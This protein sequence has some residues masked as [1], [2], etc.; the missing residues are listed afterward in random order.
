MANPPRTPAKTPRRRVSLTSKDETPSQFSRGCPLPDV[1]STRVSQIRK[2]VSASS[3]PTEGQSRVTSLTSPR[4][5]H[6]K[7][8]P[9][10][11]VIAL[12][13]AVAQAGLPLSEAELFEGLLR[14]LGARRPILSVAQLHRTVLPALG[15]QHES[16]LRHALQHREA[17]VFLHEATTGDGRAALAI[18]LLPLD[19]AGKL[20]LLL[21]VELLEQMSHSFVARAVA[22]VLSE[23][24][25]LF[26]RVLAVV[27]SGSPPM[28]QAFATNGI[29]G[30]VLSA[31]LHVPCLLHQLE[32]MMELWPDRL[33]RLGMLL[34][35][36]E[37]TFGRRPALRHRYE[38]FLQERQLSLSL[39]ILSTEMGP[40]AWLKKATSIAEHLPLLPEFVATD[41]EEGPLMMK[42]K[43][44]LG[45]S[46]EELVAE[47]TFVAE[48]ASSLLNMAHFLRQMGEPLA[49]RV[50]G[51]LD[52]LRVSFSYHLDTRLGPNTER[53][54]ALC[55]PPLM[56]RFRGILARSLARLEHLFDS[57][58]AMS[59]LRAV[60]VLDPKQL[61]AVGRSGLE[62]EQ[63]IPG[64]AEV[65]EIEWFRYQHLAEA[66]P[67]NVSLPQWWEVHA[68]QLPTLSPLARRYLWLPVCSPKS[69]F[70][71][72]EVLKLRGAEE[73]LTG[74]AARLLCMLKYNRNR[75]LSRA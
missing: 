54:L 58:P 36:L 70:G 72:G 67:A 16:A 52:S 9:N 14:L 57:H 11:L 15:R 59:A 42:L 19:R 64:L 48:H 12:V 38:L 51:E 13:Q 24:H 32:L 29:L 17:F 40:E 43:A 10:P 46:N 33:E 53:Q 68:E 56:D 61:G 34:H 39:P 28:M 47:A 6:A 35:L 63:G 69:P 5:C 44:F 26:H 66:A 3:L 45:E 71:P 37:D 21:G 74:E 20:P 18:S 31:A 62:H 65:P 55:Q 25:V 73:S 60:R 8:E 1:C 41:E 50:Y 2:Q 22:R 49:H 4:C 7:S 27:T 30:A 75:L 23:G